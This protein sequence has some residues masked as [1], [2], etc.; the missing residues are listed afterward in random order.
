MPTYSVFYFRDSILHD[1]EALTAESVVQV[2]SDAS[3]C[4]PSSLVEI[5]SENKKRAVLRP[6][7]GSRGDA[8]E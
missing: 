7:L 1:S 4:Y 3:A 6:A 8:D 5:W 2:I